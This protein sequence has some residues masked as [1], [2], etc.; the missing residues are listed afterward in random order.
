MPRA[1]VK[2]HSAV[3]APKKLSCARRR[4]MFT[5]L[6]ANA[7]AAACNLMRSRGLFMPD[8]DNAGR[9]GYVSAVINI[10]W[11]RS[12]LASLSRCERLA[13]SSGF[14]ARAAA[15]SRRG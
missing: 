5:A 9:W 6:L 10:V 1:T 15:S 7:A 8:D 2:A 12:L 13:S 14:E 3:Q 4:L 11:P